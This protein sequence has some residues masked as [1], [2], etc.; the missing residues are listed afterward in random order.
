MSH[1]E[2]IIVSKI[3]EGYEL[4]IFNPESNSWDN[5]IAFD[6]S[7]LDLQAS[8]IHDVDILEVLN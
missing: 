4:T 1:K 3:D 8:V 5:L 7:S 6:L 2:L